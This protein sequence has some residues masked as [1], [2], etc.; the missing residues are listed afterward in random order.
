MSDTSLFRLSKLQRRRRPARR[1]PQAPVATS[2]ETESSRAAG[3]SG[4]GAPYGQGTAKGCWAAMARFDVAVAPVEGRAR[5]TAVAG[6]LPFKSVRRVNS[7]HSVTSSGPLEAS[8]E[9]SFRFFNECGV[10]QVTR[11]RP[12]FR[13]TTRHRPE[14]HPH[15]SPPSEASPPTL[16]RNTGSIPSPC[17]SAPA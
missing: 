14:Q 15:P 1:V 9:A 16:R 8:F 6:S 7:H 17:R 5:L 2:L 10:R 11:A 13:P 3:A 4:A 12:P